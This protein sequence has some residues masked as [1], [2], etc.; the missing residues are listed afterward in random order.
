MELALNPRS[1]SFAD[2][3]DFYDLDYDQPI[4]I[5]VTI[6]GLPREFSSD[7][8]Y[9]MHLRGWNE[10]ASEIEDEPG[11]GLQ[12]VLS[13]CVTVDRTHEAR[14]SLYNNRIEADG[15]SDPPALRYKDAQHLAT[16]RLLFST[17]QRFV[18]LSNFSSERIE[19]APGRTKRA[20]HVKLTL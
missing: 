5:V 2:D 6:G 1:Y 16:T 4:N 7:D 12:N 9:G 17:R 13:L 19:N 11:A 8:R 20:F 18:Q 14:W 3:S 10:E 15:N